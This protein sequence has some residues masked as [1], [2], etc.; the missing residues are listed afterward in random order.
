MPESAT[1]NNLG[2]Y[3]YSWSEER[4]GYVWRKQRRHIYVGEYVPFQISVMK[5]AKQPWTDQAH[6][7]AG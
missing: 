1:A 2:E 3:Y 4:L 6:R 7:K 5:S